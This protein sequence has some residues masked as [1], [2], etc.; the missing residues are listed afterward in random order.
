MQKIISPAW[1]QIAFLGV[2]GGMQR[3]ALRARCGEPHERGATQ[4][5]VRRTRLK[6]QFVTALGIPCATIVLSLLAGCTAPAVKR[7]TYDLINTEMSRALE[8]KS[9][10][11]QPDTVS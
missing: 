1:S 5:C 2:S 7:E 4:Q 10:P 11:A 8:T 3:K 9:Q 6:T